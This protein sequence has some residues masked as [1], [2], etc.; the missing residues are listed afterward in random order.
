MGPVEFAFIDI[1]LL[2]SSSVNLFIGYLIP[3]ILFSFSTAC[4]SN[5]KSYTT[6]K[7]DVILFNIFITSS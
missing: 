5:Y 3:S 2:F 7:G 4:T 1:I 6:H